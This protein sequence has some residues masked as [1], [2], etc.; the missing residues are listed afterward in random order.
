MEQDRIRTTNSRPRLWRQLTAGALAVV[1]FG[2]VL[3]AAAR[4]TRADLTLIFRNAPLHIVPP[5]HVLQ[6]RIFESMVPRGSTVFYITDKPEAWQL[7]L[8]QR[9]LY[10]DYVVIPVGSSAQFDT[11]AYRS[12]RARYL[13]R[14]A[15]AAGNPPPAVRFDWETELPTYPNGIRCVLGRLA[16]DAGSHANP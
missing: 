9:S 12:A 16:D 14:Y 8:W 15:I 10:P 2:S 3:F 11:P 1:V 7:G 5:G 6:V 4:R 13:V